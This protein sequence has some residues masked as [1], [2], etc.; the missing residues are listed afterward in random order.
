MTGRAAI[1]CPLNAGMPAAARNGAQPAAGLPV[2]ALLLLF[3]V[4]AKVIFWL[5]DPDPRFF[6]GDSA[7]YINAATRGWGLRDRSST[8]PLM[9]WLI[10]L[11]GQSLQALVLVQSA[12]GVLLAASLYL[13]LVRDALVRPWLAALAVLLIAIEPMQLYY[14]RSVMAETFG[15]ASLVA[16]LVTICSYFR[17]PTMTRIVLSAALGIAA[18]SFRL[19]LLPTV[20]VLGSLFPA[21]WLLVRNQRPM[22][23]Q[24]DD[25]SPQSTSPARPAAR[26]VLFHLGLAALATAALHQGYRLAYG[27]LA[28]VSPGYIASSGLFRLTWLA[29]LV[30]PDD[31][32]RHGVSADL[33]HELAQDHRDRR[34][35]ERQMW[36]SDGLVARLRAEHPD[37]ADV[38]AGRIASAIVVRRPLSVLGL[39]LSTFADHFDPLY[40][41]SRMQ[42]DLGEQ[43][44]DQRFLDQV[45]A[46]FEYDA[47]DWR[48][49]NGLV[50][51]MLES[52]RPLLTVQL[53]LAPVLAILLLSLAISRA[54]PQL[55]VLALAILGLAASNVLFGH[56]LVYRY[57]HPLPPLLIVAFAVLVNAVMNRN[58]V[59]T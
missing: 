18:V 41:H 10:A 8:Y 17:R 31:L 5:L 26:Q 42:N 44:P 1:A 53:L 45:Q 2:A 21:L 51:R 49:T 28:G 14:E 37:D 12:L 25:R 19:S 43:P 15:T 34:S 23:K 38:I 46:L 24:A 52:A 58:G 55:A 13:L 30:T 3:L 35:R 50:Y 9:I 36:S 48:R 54:S 57:L 32:S 11:P 39:G 47:S 16:M 6:F 56:A 59:R 33:L 22:L 20:L 40:A 27:H 4:L 7:S 29:P